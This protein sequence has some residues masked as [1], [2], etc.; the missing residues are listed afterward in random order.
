ML[1]DTHAIS[2]IRTFR[3]T[4]KMD[5]TLSRGRRTRIITIGTGIE[6]SARA[7]ALL[8]KY[9]P[10]YAVIGIHPT[11][12][13]DE[14]DDFLPELRELAEHPVAAIGETGQTIIISQQGRAPKLWQWPR[15]GGGS[16]GCP[17]CARSL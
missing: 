14:A 16:R 2:T 3:R 6:S 13:Q 15:S 8:E 5:R 9:S 12:V 17:V 10:V 7:I 1:I 11:N 4:S